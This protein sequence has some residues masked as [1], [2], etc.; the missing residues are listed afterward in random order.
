VREYE[1]Y[2]IQLAKRVEL[3]EATLVE[4]VEFVADGATPAI[5]RP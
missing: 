2:L 5:R 4:V 1:R 3:D